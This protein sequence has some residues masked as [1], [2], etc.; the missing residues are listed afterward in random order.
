MVVS[1]PNC[2]LE[3]PTHSIEDVISL[4]TNFHAL[5][6][7]IDGTDEATIAYTGA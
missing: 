5:P 7:S 3:I 4:E 2:H 6:S 1:M